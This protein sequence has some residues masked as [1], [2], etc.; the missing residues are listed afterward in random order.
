MFSKNQIKFFCIATVLFYVIAFYVSDFVVKGDSIKLF[1]E[2]N[3]LFFSAFPYFIASIICFVGLNRVSVRGSVGKS[4]LFLGISMLANTLGFVAWFLLES[5]FNI[6][7]YPSVADF[8]YVIFT[9]TLGVGVAF[10]LKIFILDVPKKV[11]VQSGF[12]VIVSSWLLLHFSGLSFP[13]FG[14]G[15]ILSNLFDTFYTFSDILFLAIVVLVIRISGGRIFN[16]LFYFLLGIFT[17]L[18]ADIIFFVRTENDIQYTGDIGDV[19]Y[20]LSGFIFAIGLYKIAL[21][22]SPKNDFSK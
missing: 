22:F 19:F 18:I 17:T 11:I 7:P 9:V 15:F 16:G 10:L 14:E 5:V 1:S 3:T 13:S 2:Y 20:I 21:N 4:F 8:F 6:S 12:L